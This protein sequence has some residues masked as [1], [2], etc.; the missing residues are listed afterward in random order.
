MHGAPSFFHVQLLPEAAMKR[1]LST[2]SL[3]LVLAAGTASANIIFSFSGVTFDDGGT[4]TG[5][6]TTDDTMS[7]VIGFVIDTQG[8]VIGTEYNPGVGGCGFALGANP[9]VLGCGNGDEALQITFVGPLGGHG[10]TIEVGPGSFERSLNFDYRRY[11]TAGR[12]VSDI[13]EPSTIWL[14]AIAGL[15]LLTS[16]PRRRVA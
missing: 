4:L 9:F 15:G 10:A 6:F 1:L 11:I 7:L 2:L 12:V 13:P 14:L 16:L 5:T 8:P 3:V